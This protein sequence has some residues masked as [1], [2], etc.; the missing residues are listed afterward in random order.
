MISGHRH[1]PLDYKL[2]RRHLMV[3]RQLKIRNKASVLSS[4]FHYLHIYNISNDMR[5]I[6]NIDGLLVAYDSIKLALMAPFIRITIR[7]FIASP[8]HWCAA[9]WWYCACYLKMMLSVNNIFISGGNAAAEYFI[10]NGQGLYLS[11]NINKPY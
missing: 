1:W 2:R 6:S 8:C 5:F 3:I 4:Y 10:R 11:L 7:N 9:E